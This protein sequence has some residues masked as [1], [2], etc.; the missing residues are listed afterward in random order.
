MD[1]LLEATYRAEGR[2]FWFRG[3]AR[4]LAPLIDRALTGVEHPQMLDC[5]CGTGRNMQQLIAHVNGRGRVSGIDLTRTGLIFARESGLT[6]LAQA[7]VMDL[8]FPDRS[9]DLVTSLDVLVCFDAAGQVQALREMLRVIRPGGALVLNTAAL[10]WLHGQHSVFAWEVHRTTRRELAAGLG[11]AGFEIERLTYTN[12][13]LLPIVLPVRIAQRV[14]GLST[15]EESGAEIHPPPGPINAALSSVL[16]LE[17]AAL[18]VCNMPLG[19]S[20]L[21]LARRP[22]A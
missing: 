14:L 18:R 21:A 20:L 7:S 13:S 22:R 19:S 3:L 16:G 5:G 10:P 8:P 2:H 1:R 12:F 15:A 6:R 9:F 11:E 17:A 4:F